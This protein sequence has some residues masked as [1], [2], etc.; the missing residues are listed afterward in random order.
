MKIKQLAKSASFLLVAGFIS[1]TIPSCSSEEEIIILQ[2]V[3][4][5]SESFNLAE[6]GSTTI[7]VKVVPEN[8]PIA[9][10]VLSTSL[11]NESGV[12]E[13]T[14]LTPK[15]NGVWQIAAKV[16]DFSRIQNGQD[17]ILSVYQEDNMYIQTTL[18]INDPYSIEGKYTPVHPQ[19]FTFYSAEDGKLM[20]IPFI[21]TAD[22]AADLA[23]ISYDNIKVV[24]GTGSSTPSISITHFAIAPMTGKTGF[25]LQVDNAQLETVKKAIT[26]IA[27]LDCRVMITGPTAVLPIL[28]CASLFLLRSASSRT[29]N[30]AC[31]I[32]NYPPRSL[33]DKSP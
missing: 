12:F 9:K 24:N 29:T 25:Y 26:T 13:V 15:G 22:N 2:D 23:A 17:V 18:N 8:T 3:K 5:N 19:A 11:F 7:E 27:F 32:Q 6:D 16:K 10:A 20:E 21:I 28:L 33:I 4:V 1:F 14:R 31:C 30:S